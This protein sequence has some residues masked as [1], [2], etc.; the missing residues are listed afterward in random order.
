MFNGG[1]MLVATCNHEI[2]PRLTLWIIVCLSWKHLVYSWREV[3]GVWLLFL[4]LYKWRIKAGSLFWL[5]LPELPSGTAGCP[6]GLVLFRTGQRATSKTCS[7]CSWSVCSGWDGPA[8]SL[9]WSPPS[10]W[11]YRNPCPTLHS[12]IILKQILKQALFLQNSE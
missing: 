6:A 7:C 9:A 3:A 11:L 1:K 4:N 10:A 5:L 2:N 8:V 12:V